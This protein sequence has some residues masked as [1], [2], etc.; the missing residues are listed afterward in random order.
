MTSRN[1]QSPSVCALL[2]QRHARPRVAQRPTARK[3][4]HFAPRVP[5]LFDPVIGPILYPVVD[6]GPP[7]HYP[8]PHAGLAQV[9]ELVDALASGASGLTVVEVRVF[10]WAP[11]Q[12]KQSHKINCPQNRSHQSAP[13]VSPAGWW[14][15]EGVDISDCREC[16]QPVKDISSES[17]YK[18]PMNTYPFCST[19][20]IG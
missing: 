17:C 9:A 12:S 15:R 3:P 11:E 4:D 20:P 1:S 18:T 5:I 19:R 7:H 16:P 6:I 10:S 2:Y 14:L 8:R 13:C